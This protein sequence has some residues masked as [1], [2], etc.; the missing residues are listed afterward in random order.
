MNYGICGW[1][2]KKVGQE[3]AL[4]YKCFQQVESLEKARESVK[5]LKYW[6]IKHWE[7]V[8]GKGYCWNT[9]ESNFLDGLK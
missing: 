7:F 5:S 9:I 3:I 1:F 6:K 8:E 2:E 4:D